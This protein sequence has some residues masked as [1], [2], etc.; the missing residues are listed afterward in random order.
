MIKSFRHRGLERYFMTGSK[1]G[2]KPA[3]A[4]RLRLQLARLNVAKHAADM[5]L[6]G[7]RLHPLHGSAKGHWAVRVDASWRLTFSF[8]DDGAID[9]DYLDYH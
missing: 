8:D 3:H 9:V 2:I 6:P 7:W 5:N 4:R 1:A